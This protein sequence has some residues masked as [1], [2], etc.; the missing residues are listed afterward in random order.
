MTL[1]AICGLIRVR[2]EGIAEIKSKRVSPESWV[3]DGDVFFGNSFRI[4][5]VSFVKTFFESVIH[6]VDGGFTILVALKSVKVV[7]LYEEKN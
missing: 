6:S 7:F 4:V 5:A 2:A 1:F 3:D